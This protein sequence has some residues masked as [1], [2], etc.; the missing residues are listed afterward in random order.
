MWVW[1]YYVG[2]LVCT[3]CCLYTYVYVT[4]LVWGLIQ[5][6]PPL[7][8]NPFIG[9]PSAHAVQGG[10]RWSRCHGDPVPHAPL[11]DHGVQADRVWSLLPGPVHKA[12]RSSTEEPQWTGKALATTS[13]HSRL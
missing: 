6:L 13:V 3:L 1:V 2:M 9:G 12:T 5:L 4:K 7:R 11:P 10:P 8:G